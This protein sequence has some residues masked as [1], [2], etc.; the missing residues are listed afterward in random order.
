MYTM[1]TLSLY[2]LASCIYITLALA[3][4]GKIVYSFMGIDLVLWAVATPLMIVPAII[5]YWIEEKITDL[6]MG[7]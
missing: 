5:I 3:F 6:L 7:Y 2:F 1:F 4:P